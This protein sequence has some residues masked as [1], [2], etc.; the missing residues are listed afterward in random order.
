MTLSALIFNHAGAGN[1]LAHIPSTGATVRQNA[2]REAIKHLMTKASDIYDQCLLIDVVALPDAGAD[3]TLNDLNGF[4]CSPVIIQTTAAL[5]RAHGL[6][7]AFNRPSADQR[8]I[9]A[10][11]DQNLLHHALQIEYDEKKT[12]QIKSVLHALSAKLSKLM[13]A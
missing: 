8:T 1:L 11:M 6:S 9:R 10:A 3:I 4:S 5:I 7:V 2:P 12:A 13:V